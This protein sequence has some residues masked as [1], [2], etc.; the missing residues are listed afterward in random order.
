MAPPGRLNRLARIPGIYSRLAW[1]GLVAP[2]SDSGL[3]H[4]ASA[5]GTPVVGVFGPTD[6][7][8]FGPR[9][10]PHRALRR[11]W[12]CSPCWHT[13][14]PQS[15]GGEAAC[16]SQL[17]VEEVCAALDELLDLPNG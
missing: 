1:W 9:G 15:A 2:R 11:P 3:L 5:C 17:L 7:D 12:P 4:L 6:P 8:R 10:V 14:C 16:L 13:R